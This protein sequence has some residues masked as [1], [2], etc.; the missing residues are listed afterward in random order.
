MNS[1][2]CIH[3]HFY[4]PPRENPW[5]ERI[6][7]QD[8][9]YPYHDWNARVHAECYAPNAVSRILDGD[10][11][12]TSIVNN[13]EHISFN[14]GPTLLHWIEKH[15]PE[16]YRK[17]VQA[18][19]TSVEQHGGHGN[20]IAQAYNHMIMPLANR[21]DKVT[22]VIWG[23]SSFR[24]HF[25][26]DPEGMWLPE[27]AVDLETLEILHEHNI[28]FTLLAPRQAKRMRPLKS[29]YWCD[30]SDGSID[31]TVPYLVRLPCGGSLAVFF[32]DG[33]I[34]HDVAFGGL[35]HS[36]E[37]FARRLFASLPSGRERPPLVTVA[38]DGETYGHHH[39]FT[40]M[41][42]A[43]ALDQVQKNPDVG[44]TNYGEYLSL[45]PPLH[46]VEIVENSSWSCVHGVDRW[47]ADCGCRAGGN[48]GWNQK[49]RRTLRESFDWLR[50]E[51]IRIYTAQASA[52][53]KNPW[54]A[55]DGYIEVIMSRS[56]AAKKKFLEKH[57]VQ[58]LSD[59]E[60]S[61]SFRLLEMQRNA[62]LMYTSCGWFFDELSGI[63][64]VQVLSYAA[65]AIELAASFTAEPLE[66]QF[67]E[68]L[69]EAKSNIQGMGS[70]ADIY[71]KFALAS[72]ANL[73]EV[74]IHFAISS[75]FEDYQKKNTLGCYTIN[76]RKYEKQ[77]HNGTVVALGML[78]ASSVV[79]DEAASFIFAA[80]QQE[81]HDYHCAVKACGAED[82]EN[83][84]P[85]TRHVSEEAYQK[86]ADS[87]FTTMTKKSPS[88]TLKIIDHY[89]GKD[90][91]TIKDLFKDEQEDLLEI[92]L[93][94]EM[95][96]VGQTLEE[97]YRKTSFLTA[98]LEEYGHRIPPPLTN[99]AEV[100]LKRK[101]AEALDNPKSTPE[102]M[103]LLLDE[104]KRWHISLDNEW[105]E[106]TLCLRLER[107]MAL[108]KE[109]H[110][111]SNIAHMNALLAML[112]LF[113]VRLNLW[114]VQNSYFELLQTCYHDKKN[115]AAAGDHDAKKWI[116][117]FIRLGDGLFINVE[118]LLAT[119]AAE[120]NG[121]KSRAGAIL[122]KR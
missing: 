27:T 16:I 59:P 17:I 120:T 6:E 39:R 108:V 72:R 2:I 7:V 19:K 95:E 97:I 107:E 89:L 63:E 83:G 58:S 52:L 34:A 90:R 93:E 35:L 60:R 98:L 47:R 85:P 21:R 14:F 102:T 44:L 22:Q 5:L 86:L 116:D 42:L 1:Y 92:I 100:T 84:S 103:R 70:G 40:D 53:L 96:Y 20:A 49:W 38:T 28:R 24:H 66:Q 30:V 65:R 9:A 106:R 88:A 54:Q 68:R 31:T 82:A 32:Y 64:S 12:I 57:G 78:D 75:F 10:G 76:L 74:A 61:Q 101:L 23:I 45:F 117:E 18:D 110:A 3:G 87:L 13:Y 113:P 104:I 50:F 99:A 43:C 8:S 112:F 105:L 114:Q 26:R 41:A 29:P 111:I 121:P 25:N 33:G 94:G 71:R 56:Q 51:L 55:R 73:K 69:Q 79:T 37:T 119:M 36:G 77:Q 81:L 15:S 91:Y 118:S 4:Q 48:Q 46:E 11:R 80:L 109:Q 67:I 62:M 122:K 115:L